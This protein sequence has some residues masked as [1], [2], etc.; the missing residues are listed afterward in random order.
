MM[1]KKIYKLTDEGEAELSRCF[2]YHPPTEG[3][4]GKCEE[5]TDVMRDA[6]RVILGVCPP[7]ADRDAALVARRS[8]RM[9][10]NA[11]IACRGQ[12][13]PG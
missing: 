8:A 4:R 6:A 7:G 12:R 3:D 13:D 1:G 11:S 2:G 5:I 10:S 9:W